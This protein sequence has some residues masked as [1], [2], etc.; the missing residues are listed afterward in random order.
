MGPVHVTR[1]RAHWI[2][3]LVEE[4]K[5]QVRSPHDLTAQAPP[6]HDEQCVLGG[7]L[8]SQN[9]CSDG[10]RFNALRSRVLAMCKGPDA[11]AER[12]GRLVGLAGV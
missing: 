2:S 8:T 4:L 11:V 10:R 5:C 7:L 3:R 12:L 1:G 6:F 9:R